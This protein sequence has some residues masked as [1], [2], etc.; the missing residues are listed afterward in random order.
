MICTICEAKGLRRCNFPLDKKFKSN[1][2]DHMKQHE[3]P[4]ITNV[5]V[6]AWYFVECG[7][8]RTK[9][10][11]EGDILLDNGKIKF[12]WVTAQGFHFCSYDLE[13]TQIA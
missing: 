3:K 8:G 6:G 2:E 9:A 12:D 4:K 7:W 1:Y 10:K 13:G 11:S 5:I